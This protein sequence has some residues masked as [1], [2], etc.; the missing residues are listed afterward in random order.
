MRRGE[1]EEDGG[2]EE[3]GAAAQGGGRGEE[4]KTARGGKGQGSQ[5]TN[6]SFHLTGKPDVRTMS[7]QDKRVPVVKSKKLD[8]LCSLER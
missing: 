7:S 2:A 5:H 8:L 1:R 3:E 4:T 6:A